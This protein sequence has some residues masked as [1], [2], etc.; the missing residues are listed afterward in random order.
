M[1]FKIS[2]QFKL[3]FVVL[4]VIIVTLAYFVF[5]S[6]NNQKKIYNEAFHDSAINLANALDAGIGSSEDLQN[7]EKLQ[8]NIYKLMWLNSNIIGI[9]ISIPT[10]TGLSVVASS[11]TDEIGKNGV[12]EGLR[13]FRDGSIILD[14]VSELDAST[15]LRVIT[16]VHIGGNRVGVYTIKLS[17][18]TLNSAIAQ[19]QQELLLIALFSILVIIGVFFFLVRQT[20]ELGR[21]KSHME[22]IIDNLGDGLLE[23]SQS[24]EIR[25]I[26]HAA[27]KLL[28]INWATVVGTQVPLKD[29]TSDPLYG[30]SKIISEPENIL[31]EVNITYPLPTTLQIV[32]APLPSS[33]GPNAGFVS[34]IR[35]VT[36]EKLIDQE[37]SSFITVAAHQMRTP[38]S[39][40]KWALS[41]LLEDHGSELSDRVKDIVKI[42][43]TTNNRM[44]SLIND[45]LAVSRIEEGRYGFSFVENDVVSLLRRICSEYTPLLEEKTLTLTTSFAD[46]IPKLIFDETKLSIAFHDI[47]DNAILYTRPGGS[48]SVRAVKENNFA[49]IYFVDTG[50]GIPRD[51]IPKLFTKFY[52][53]ENAVLVSPDGSGLGLYIVKNII[54]QHEGTVEVTPNTPNGTIFIVRLPLNRK[55]V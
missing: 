22:T 6:V 54:T 1:K 30:I 14:Q 47:I 45:L 7:V 24:G 25:R 49:V 34:M 26:N 35:D 29:E 31:R 36:R 53:G 42:G 43:M 12:P 4:V 23:Y 3:L 41:A 39:A 16:P 11:K 9:S 19:T 55:I 37:K 27:E 52:R 33:L 20:N 51:S 38:L 17:Q 10:E 50:I 32:T 40:T 28:G 13:S 48:V 15:V 21:S 18:D 2:S 44:I 8:S 5:V 46:D